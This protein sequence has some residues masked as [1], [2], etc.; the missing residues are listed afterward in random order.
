M[1]NENA[2]L[3]IRKHFKGQNNFMTPH[4]M[5]RD[6]AVPNKIAYELS[7]GEG[8]TGDKIFGVTVVKIEKDGT[9]KQLDDLGGCC[10]SE[11]EALERIANI[12]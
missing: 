1:N 8:F 6:W 5:K 10:H 9:T 4:M 3:V 7:S 2:S 12:K 11:S